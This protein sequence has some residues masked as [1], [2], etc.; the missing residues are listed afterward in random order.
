MGLKEYERGGATTPGAPRS[1]PK[2]RGGFCRTS[3]RRRDFR[4]D[5]D[6]GDWSSSSEPAA[7]ERDPGTRLVTG[8]KRSG[9]LEPTAHAWPSREN[10]LSAP[11]RPSAIH[12]R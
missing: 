10:S 3:Q 6:R 1:R 7:E 4:Q 8:G 11:T 2:P 5:D 9:M 12:S